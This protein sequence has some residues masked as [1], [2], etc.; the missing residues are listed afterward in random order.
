MA[1]L[2]QAIMRLD[3]NVV[4]LFQLFLIRRCRGRPPTQLL[5]ARL[6]RSLG[7]LRLTAMID[8]KPTI[9]LNACRK[10]HF[11]E[12]LPQTVKKLLGPIR[13]RLSINRSRRR[14]TLSISTATDCHGTNQ[15]GEHP[16]NGPL[17]PFGQAHQPGVLS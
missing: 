10:A 15:N 8:H 5:S 14:F 2:H 4:E 1:V 11:R 12:A 17:K 9:G 16:S 13:L 6:F 3:L 7:R